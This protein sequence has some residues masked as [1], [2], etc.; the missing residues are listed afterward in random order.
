MLATNFPLFQVMLSM[1]W[2]FIFVLWIMLVF[3]VFV[4]IFRSDD[5]SGIAKVAWL[6]FVIAFIYLGVFVYLIA[7]GGKMAQREVSDRQAQQAAME[8]YIRSA[9]GTSASAADELARLA[10]LKDKGVIDDAE[11]NRLKAKVLG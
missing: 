5:L 7:R 2:F 3:R 9:A 6:I 10:D 1:F 8:D 4:D 11:F